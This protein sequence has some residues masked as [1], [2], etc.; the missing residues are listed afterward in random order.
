MQR[1]ASVV[2]YLEGILKIA[3]VFLAVVAGIIAI[4]LFK[5]S[6]KRKDLKPWMFLIV[7]LVFFAIQEILGALRAFA[8]YRSP[9]LTHINPTIILGLII[10][11]LLL[12]MQVKR[13]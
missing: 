7:A 8:I 12:Q 6:Q 1:G 13:K 5:V 9:F 10:T 11:A 3:N 4:S 2:E